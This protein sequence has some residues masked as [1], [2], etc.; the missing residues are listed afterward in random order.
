MQL[1][2][3]QAKT[4][5]GVYIQLHCETWP[6]SA[7]W[8]SWTLC[9]TSPQTLPL[10]TSV[11]SK[12]WVLSSRSII[13]SCIIPVLLSGSENWVLNHSLLDALNSF[14]SELG[15]HVLKLSKF[16]S[17]LTPLPVLNWPT[18]CARLLCNKLSFLCRM[19]NG[20]STSLST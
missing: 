16:S 8:V 4:D 17:N 7:L 1:T 9:G 5:H 3:V 18:M 19:C 12:W 14:Q 10:C 20:E 2:I 11:K 6:I 15:Q 13:E